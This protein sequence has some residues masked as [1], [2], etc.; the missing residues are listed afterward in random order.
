MRALKIIALAIAVVGSVQLASCQGNKQ[1]SELEILDQ[2]SD[3][4]INPYEAL[5]MLLQMQKQNEGELTLKDLGKAVARY[6]KEKN[7]EMEDILNELDENENGVIEYSEV[8]EE[9]LRQF[10][11]MMDVDGSQ[12]VTRDEMLNFR[13]E[14]AM[15]MSDKEL[16]KEIKYIFKSVGKADEID[17]T[18]LNEEEKEEVA[19][20][21]LNK[22]GKVTPKEAFDYMKPNNMQAQFEIKNGIAYMQGVI[23]SSTPAKVLQLVFEHPEVKTIEMLHVPG[24][25]DDVSNLRASLYIKRFGLNTQLNA[26]SVIAS[27][28]TD[29]FLAGTKRTVAKGAKI[30]V[31]SWGG[32]AKKA[33]DLPKNHKEHRKYLNY[34]KQVDIPADFYWFTLKAAPAE[35]IHNMTEEELVKYKIRKE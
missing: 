3:G 30:G 26:Q 32:G 10:M 35:S 24:S 13:Y 6:Q 27:G 34:Y 28:G 31:H 19:D 21:D 7:Q 2:N 18:K 20:W 33:T 8:K 12:S 1:K 15:F 4:V 22:D 23:C 9:E 14:D 29:F 16:K 11:A 17:L 5:D 25:I